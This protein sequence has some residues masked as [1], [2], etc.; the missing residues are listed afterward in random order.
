MAE[1][2]RIDKDILSCYQNGQHY[3]GFEN[4][5]E[6]LVTNKPIV[7]YGN[8]LNVGDKIKGFDSGKERTSFILMYGHMVYKGMF[9]DDLLFEIHDPKHSNYQADLFQQRP[10]WLLSFGLLGENS[11]L[12]MNSARNCYYDIHPFKI[13]KWPKNPK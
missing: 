6:S 11:G 12:L 8:A 13:I 5:S 2:Y 9:T 10:K 7:L 3:Y 1:V 4:G